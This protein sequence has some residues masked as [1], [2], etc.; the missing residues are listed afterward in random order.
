M[1]DRMLQA[2]TKLKEKQDDLGLELK[3]LT[4]EFEKTSSLNMQEAILRVADDLARYTIKDGNWYY[5]GKDT[6]IKAEAIDGKDGERGPQGIPGIQGKPGKDGKNGKDGKPGKDGKNG[7]PGKDGK[8]GK[9]GKD[10]RDGKDGITPLIKI[11]KVE[12]SD[13]YGGGDV[14]MRFGK[15]NIIYLDFTL[16]MGRQG[17]AGLDGK[18]AKINGKNVIN[19]IA[20]NNISVEQEGKN[21]T[22]N[23][24]VNPFELLVVSQLP[25]RDISSSAIYFV[26]SSTSEAS[27]I[28]D[29]WVYVNKGTEE[30]PEFVWEHL[31]STAIDLTDYVKKTDYATQNVGGVVKMWTSTVDGEI[32]LNISTQ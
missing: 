22:I 12:F 27:N 13:T 7:L 2:I 17:F 32:G 4:K 10:G 8:N 23:S 30:S 26:P 28:F 20:G 14:K 15:G 31:G 5:N 16:P 24:L 3:Q 21:L 29:E 11:G 1:N 9:D 25:T 6:G 18:D 19:I